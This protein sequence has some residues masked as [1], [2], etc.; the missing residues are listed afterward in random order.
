MGLYVVDPVSMRE[1]D[2][3]VR[4]GP[5]IYERRGWVCTWWTLYL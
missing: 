5:C 2:G 4:G 1:E 3:F